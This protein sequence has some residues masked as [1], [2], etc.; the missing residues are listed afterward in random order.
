M[1]DNDRCTHRMVLFYF[2]IKKLGNVVLHSHLRTM[3]NISET[4]ATRATSDRTFHHP[5]SL[6]GKR[7]PNMKISHPSLTLSSTQSPSRAIESDR[8][9]DA[10]GQAKPPGSLARFVPLHVFKNMNRDGHSQPRRSHLSHSRFFAELRT[11]LGHE[12]VEGRAYGTH[13]VPCKNNTNPHSKMETL[14]TTLTL[15]CCTT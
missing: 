14:R 10:S 1:C 15:R 9:R 3:G 11:L 5:S 12:F 7:N 8:A 13:L 6:H 2:V 4:W